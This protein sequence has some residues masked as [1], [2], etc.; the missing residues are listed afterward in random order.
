MKELLLDSALSNVTPMKLG[1]ITAGME[2]DR[3]AGLP[4]AVKLS[5]L[6]LRW[7]EFFGF[8]FQVMWNRKL[9]LY[10]AN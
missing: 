9:L 3:T 6:K 7:V 10:F 2:R 5:L 8:Y 1:N 4:Q